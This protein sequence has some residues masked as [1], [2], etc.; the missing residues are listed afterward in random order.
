MITASL[1]AYR[2]ELD[3]NAVTASTV[4]LPG[5]AVAIRDSGGDGPLVVF[6]HGVL[7]DGR[8]WDG[9]WPAIAAAGY[10]CVLPD[11]PLGAHRRPLD[12][13]A[14]RSPLGQARRVAALIRALGAERAV[15][16]GNDSG[17][18]VC[19]LLTADDP[20]VVDRL[21]LTPADAFNHF[22]P[23]LFRPLPFLARSPRV[24]G[25]ALWP[26]TRRPLRRLPGVFGWLTKRPIP[27]AL[28][29]DWFG[30]LFADPAV[31]RDVA[32]FVAPM[33][34]RLTLDAAERLRTFPRPALMAWAT[35][36]RF[37]PYSD[38]EKLAALMPQGRIVPIRDSYTFTPLDQPDAT[39]AAIVSFLAGTESTA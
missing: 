32:G 39:A 18:A 7:V 9:V 8:L 15:L 38:G 3:V 20:D 17:G 37:F 25:A 14:D 26:L 22:P 24:L 30:A 12:P 23:A 27:T 5:G 29:D 11:L 21:V 13:G 36:D 4:D 16:V 33:K 31:M 19:Q 35:E 1:L 2:S 6:V 28:T 34:P 10:R